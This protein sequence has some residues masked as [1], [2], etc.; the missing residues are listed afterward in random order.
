M[1]IKKNKGDYM[2]EYIILLKKVPL[3]KHIQEKNLKLVSNLLKEREFKKGDTIV[4][5]GDSGVG[6][7]IIKSG[8]VKIMKKLS[9]GKEID[10]AVHGEGEFFGELSVLDDKPRTASVIALENVQTVAMTHWE[11]KAL[12][13]EHPAIALDILP[14]IIERFRETNEQL[15]ELKIK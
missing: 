4:K 5:Q 7:F 10:I 13:E 3:F 6:L 2:G 11:F 12:L 14:V 1:N 9:D 8:K 15:L